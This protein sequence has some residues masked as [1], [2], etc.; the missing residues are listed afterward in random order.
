MG[1][2]S[3]IYVA[4]HHSKVAEDIIGKLRHLGFNN[5]IKK[6]RYDLDLTSQSEVANFFNNGS[7]EYVF[8][9]AARAT[10]IIDNT[11]NPA[12]CFLDNIQIQNNVLSNCFMHNEKKVI[13]FQH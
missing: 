11:N 9:L 12:E 8:L 10:E 5:I 1:K 13:F 3:K 7:I 2:T 4:G 6:E